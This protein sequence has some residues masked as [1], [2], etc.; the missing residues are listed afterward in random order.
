MTGA[1]GMLGRAL[2]EECKKEQTEYVA[3]TR[4]D[5]DMTDV[6]QVR[7]FICE[8]APDVVIHCAAYTK[9]DLAESEPELCHA[10]NAAGTWAVAMACKETDA[11]LCYLSTDYVFHGEG[12]KPH[13]ES[14]Q[15]RPLSVYGQSKYEGE[16]AAKSLKK[17]Y[18]V[19]ASWTYGDDGESFLTTMLRLGAGKKQISVVNDQIGAPVYAKELAPLLLALVKTERYGT[20]HATGQGECSFADYAAYIM[21]TAGLPAKIV[22]VSSEQYVQS[23]LQSMQAAGR[24]GRIA[25]RPKNS[26]L[27]MEELKKAGLELLPDWKASVKRA[28]EYRK[29]RENG[30]NK[31]E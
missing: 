23:M 11:A 22:P 16:L 29:E 21:E 18:I 19:R 6:R 4:A 17:H 24:T 3:M 14:E 15:P 9:V 7:R 2:I 30:E 8:Q 5:A 26:R 28:I 31:T 27:S 12:Y 1:N 20:Y 13:K 10:V 25:E